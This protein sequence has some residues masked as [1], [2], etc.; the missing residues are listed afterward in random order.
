MKK[1]TTK[2]TRRITATA[3]DRT[4]FFCIDEPNTEHDE[5]FVMDNDKIGKAIEKF[6]TGKPIEEVLDHLESKDYKRTHL[7]AER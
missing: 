6:L 5:I 3:S 7:P 1:A 4:L 2:A